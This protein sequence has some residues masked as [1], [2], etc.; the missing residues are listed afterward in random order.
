MRNVL[1]QF[2]VDL[3]GLD[4]SRQRGAGIAHDAGGPAARH[5]LVRHHF[6]NARLFRPQFEQHAQPLIDRELHRLFDQVQR[7]GRAPDFSPIISAATVQD[8]LFE[9]GQ[10]DFKVQLVLRAVAHQLFHLGPVDLDV[11]G[12]FQ[13]PAQALYEAAPIV[14]ELICGELAQAQQVGF[15][16]ERQIRLLQL[17]QPFLV[18]HV[19]PGGEVAEHPLDTVA[20]RVA[21]DAVGHQMLSDLKARDRDEGFRLPGGVLG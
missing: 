17:V 11:V 12:L 2:D 8:A 16:T 21:P 19:A 13:K 6:G 9:V 14:L 7:P 5:V 15:R 1:E 10:L 18:N 20:R 4:A 3:V